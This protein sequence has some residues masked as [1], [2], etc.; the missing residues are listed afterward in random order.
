MFETSKVAYA[1]DQQVCA[2]EPYLA[3]LDRIEEELSR[4][5]NLIEN[6]I[7][8]CRGGGNQIALNAPQPPK[9]T[10]HFATIERIVD[11][12]A[13]IDRASRELGTIG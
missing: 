9:A 10:G 6:F 2:D 5:A 3:R 13:R 4:S 8:R 1:A 12:M 7:D 11:Q